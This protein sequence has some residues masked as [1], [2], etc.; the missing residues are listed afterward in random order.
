[1]PEVIYETVPFHVEGV[2]GSELG[3]IVIRKTA[4]R[5]AAELGALA[6]V[7][8]F[9]RG[10]VASD[11][12]E[13]S[14]LMGN[15]NWPGA[16]E[17]V[18]KATQYLKSKGCKKVG[19]T[20]FCMGGALTIASAVHVDGL[21]AGVCFYG[22]PNA[23]FASPA[24]IKTPMQFHFGANDKSTGFSDKESAL[25]LK[26]ELAAAGKDTSEFY[27][28]EGADHAFMNEEAT[29]FPYNEAI[30]KQAFAKTIDFFKKHLH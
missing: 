7:P 10:K 13:A 27:I 20:G 14:H 2:E 24:N 16:V 30:A 19:V 23:S 11:A 6:V 29:A 28:W 21:S 3:V 26:G 1:M 5:F 4:A 8:D 17:D 15:L 22:I 25:K 12:D 18:R 9:Y